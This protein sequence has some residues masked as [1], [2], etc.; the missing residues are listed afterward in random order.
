M[1]ELKRILCPVDLSRH[2]LVALDL[3]S[4]LAKANDAE[5][6]IFYVA[7]VWMPDESL[8]GQEYIQNLVQE[9]QKQFY[10]LEP[11]VPGV[12]FQRKFVYGNPGPEIV[13]ETENHDLVV[14]STHGR[15]GLKRILMGSV[16]E[17]VVRH[18]R[19]P[20]LSIRAKLDSEEQ[21][22]TPIKNDSFVTQV[23]RG[24]EPIRAWYDMSRAIDSMTRTGD[25]A[26]P[27][28]NETGVVCGILTNTD[29]ERYRELKR[30]LEQ[31]DESVVDEVFQTDKYGQRRAAN[32]DFDKVTRHMTA[33]VVT[34][35]AT[36][37]CG[38]AYEIWKQHPDIHHLV[39]VDEHDRPVGVIPVRDNPDWETC[40][41]A[42]RSSDQQSTTADS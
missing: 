36:Q 21:P 2:S 13:R 17:Y 9:T 5:L 23:M 31:G 19:C 35:R 34:V 42:S 16:A 28:V 27:V 20:V 8:V 15:R 7:E 3:A 1:K 37:S 24:T 4:R 12:R 39:V 10:E 33:P 11:T 41:D 26:A 14:I 29:I 18:A 25:S 40:V 22:A 30:R 38:E 32:D 6:T